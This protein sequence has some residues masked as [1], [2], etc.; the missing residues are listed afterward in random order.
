MTTAL[1]VLLIG[2]WLTAALFGVRAD[3][4]RRSARPMFFECVRVVGRDTPG[5][6]RP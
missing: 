4:Q 3:R 5:E 6:P 1:T 2:V